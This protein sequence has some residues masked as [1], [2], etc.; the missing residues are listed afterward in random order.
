MSLTLPEISQLFD[1]LGA[2]LYGG[3][4]ITQREHALQA[5]WSAEQAGEEDSL[6]IACLLHD[7]GHLLFEQNDADLASGKDD[8]HQFKIIPFLRGLLPP[9]VTEPI[10]LHVDAKRYLCQHE[11]AYYE[12]LSAAS[13]MSLA[14]QGGIMDATAASAFATHPYA[15]QAIA[16]R[17]YDDAAKVVGLITPPFSHFLP[18]LTALAERTAATCASTT[19]PPY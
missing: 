4:A 8:L 9:E 13:K 16:L 19:P 7:L 1:H 14:L 17:R 11:A 12:A 6:I 10:R 15:S 3:E 2:R 18:T 5:A